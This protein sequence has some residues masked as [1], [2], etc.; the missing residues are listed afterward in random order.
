MEGRDRLWNTA[1][2]AWR[3]NLISS[4]PTLWISVVAAC[5]RAGTSILRIMASRCL[6]ILSTRNYYEYF[7]P[8][9]HHVLSCI[10]QAPVWAFGWT[11]VTPSRAQLPPDLREY[12]IAA[13]QWPQSAASPVHRIGGVMYSRSCCALSIPGVLPFSWPLHIGCCSVWMCQCFT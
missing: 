11:P 6:L 2:L 3:R 8:L 7:S 12:I 5:T 1:S 4:H 13:Q 10:S 9:L